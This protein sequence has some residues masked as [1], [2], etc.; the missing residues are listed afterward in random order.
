MGFTD[1]VERRFGFG[2]VLEAGT[3]VT[4]TVE[5]QTTPE[6]TPISDTPANRAFM[7]RFCRVN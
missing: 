4:D 1:F 3:A 7:N 6:E 5:P 2:E